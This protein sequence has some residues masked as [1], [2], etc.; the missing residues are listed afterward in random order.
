MKIKKILTTTFG[1]LMAA[2]YIL[3][4]DYI[5]IGIRRNFTDSL[6]Y[7]F[8]I[9]T[10]LP[11]LKHEMFVSFD[12][13]SS[14]LPLAKQVIGLPGD[15][16]K[17]IDHE[18]YINGRL[19]GYIHE[20]SPSNKTFHPIKEGAIPEG[21]VFVYS[22]HFYSFDSRYAEFGLIEIAK[23]RERLWPIF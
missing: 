8:F 5:N 7:T 4:S 14:S 12:H 22:P 2:I 19:Y 3:V 17:V 6:P 18:I 23:L 11:E 15:E 20:K 10:R 21:H 1:L 16:I 9:S 13:P